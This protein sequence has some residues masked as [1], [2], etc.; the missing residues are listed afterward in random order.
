M[1][2]CEG[3]FE[4]SVWDSKV[5]RVVKSLGQGRDTVAEWEWQCTEM[6]SI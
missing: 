2:F 5:G 1:R 4:G 6:Q 3:S